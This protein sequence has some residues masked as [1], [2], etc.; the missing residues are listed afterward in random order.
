MI[1]LV[2]AMIG[3]RIVDAKRNELP[4][5][6]GEGHLPSDFLGI[7][8]RLGPDDDDFACTLDLFVELFA[9][10]PAGGHIAVPPDDVAAL[11]ESC[12]A[13]GQ[14]AS[15]GAGVGNH[16]VDAGFLHERRLH[17][18]TLNH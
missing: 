16:Q 1:E 10:F 3:W 14:R 17:I 15:I 12:R 9:P 11:D 8:S 18:R 2:V 4:L 6:V 13:I 5:A 7:G